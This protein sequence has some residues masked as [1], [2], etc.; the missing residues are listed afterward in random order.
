M[1]LHSD[2]N[3]ILESSHISGGKEDFIIMTVVH[4]NVILQ[5]LKSKCVFFHCASLFKSQHIID[6]CSEI[7]CTKLGQYY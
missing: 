1:R 5:N 4:C 7:I 2:S 6:C 3:I